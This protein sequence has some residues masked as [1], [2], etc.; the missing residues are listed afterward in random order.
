MMDTVGAQ[1][2]ESKLP[3]SQWKYK[4]LSPSVTT[5]A[6]WYVGS[7]ASIRGA[8][9]PPPHVSK[10]LAELSGV[11]IADILHVL[12]A[13][14]NDYFFDEGPKGG[15]EIHEVT[16]GILNILTT[17]YDAGA[18]KFVCADLPNLS[19]TPCGVKGAENGQQFDSAHGK[20]K[21][22]LQRA[23][24]HW[25]SEHPDAWVLGWSLYD[26]MADRY[27][28]GM[29]DIDSGHPDEFDNVS[30]PLF[31]GAYG[32][33]PDGIQ[34][35]K[36]AKE[37]GERYM[38]CDPYHPSQRLHTHFLKSFLRITEQVDRSIIHEKFGKQTGEP[39]SF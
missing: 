21:V 12:V 35:A 30:D 2:V 13:G 22:F 29:D 36:D 39:W 23:I 18:R 31:V 20:H 4:V 32:P 33:H 9:T 19:L 16:D 3:K 17:L 38:F 34:P 10:R 26:L 11:K 8:P 37:D 24:N 7:M 6:N 25:V 14:A 28:L 27:A 5:Q 15:I 1:L